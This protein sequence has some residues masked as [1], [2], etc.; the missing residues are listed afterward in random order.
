MFR[1][2]ESCFEASG[3][4]AKAYKENQ[5]QNLDIKN[6]LSEAACVNYL[7]TYELACAYYNTVDKELFK[8]LY[9][10]TIKTIYDGYIKILRVFIMSGII[11]MLIC[12]YIELLLIQWM[13]IE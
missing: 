1:I 2:Q 5:K 12:I 4:F 9:Y 10:V 3:R 13:H 8:S 7:N 11:K 6:D